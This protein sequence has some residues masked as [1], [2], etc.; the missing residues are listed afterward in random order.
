MPETPFP[1]R[2][3]DDTQ[4][5]REFE[6]AWQAGEEPNPDDFLTR[7]DS[8][9][10]QEMLT[11]LLE[12]EIEIRWRRWYSLQSGTD[13]RMIVNNETAV[14]DAASAANRPVLEFYLEEYPSM[15]ETAALSSLVKKE[16]EVRNAHGD[17]V[18]LSEYRER[19]PELAESLTVDESLVLRDKYETRAANAPSSEPLNLDP[20]Q[21]F[22]GYELIK[23]IGSGGMGLVYLA[24]QISADRIVALKILRLDRIQASQSSGMFLERFRVEARATSRIDHPGIVTIYD[25]GEF[26]GLPYY[27]MKY[28]EGE[29]LDQLHTR[30]PLSQREAARIISASARA[31]QAA[32]RCGILHRDLK[33][34]NILIDRKTGQPCLADFGLAKLI[35]DDQSQT[36][37][38]DVLGT[39]GFMSPEQAK[40]SASVTVATDVYGLGATLYFLLTGKA[41]FSGTTLVETLR[42]LVNDP[43][44]PPSSHQPEL[45]SDLEVICLK[46][47]EKE[48]DKRYASA[49]GFADDLDRWLAGKP[50]HARPV[51]QAERIFRWC[52]RNP[53]STTLMAISL[54]SLFVALAASV[55]G[56]VRVSGALAE[57]EESYRQARETVNEFFTTVSEDVLLQ[58]PAMQPLRKEL[59][60]KA[61]IYYRDFQQTRGS[62]PG[63]QAEIAENHYRIGRIEELIEDRETALESYQRA[64]QLQ[65]ALIESAEDPGAIQ[66]ALSKTLNRQAGCHASL[67]DL[68]AASVAVEESL[69]IRKQLVQDTPEDEERVRLL[70]NA[71][72]NLGLLDSREGSFDEAVKRFQ[73]S[74]NRRK[75][76]L[77]SGQPSD[78]NRDQGMCYYNL[79]NLEADIERYDLAAGSIQRAI[80]QFEI[81]LAGSSDDFELRRKL[82][83]S[84][85]LQ[86]ELY[87]GNYQS[88]EA[89]ESYRLASDFLE[90]LLFENPQ[91]HPLREEL[92]QVEL[93][94]GEVY[95]EQQETETSLKSLSNSIDQ[96]ER[97]P[98]LTLTTQ[99]MLAKALQVRAFVW[100]EMAETDRARDDLERAISLLKTLVVFAPE[101]NFLQKQLETAQEQLRSLPPQTS[102]PEEL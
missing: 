2:S 7:V 53:F 52:K 22:D 81:C 92:A 40:S 17:D 21:E 46:S 74:L 61:L 64:E 96:M 63:L 50:I 19:F 93:M 30:L 69:S 43:V 67:G 62:H 51:S 31:L 54:C 57:S 41:P 39:P 42:L 26:D 83:L 18:A 79:A 34:Q 98:E 12:I 100:R 55:I 68:Q 58:Q 28:V 77:K 38:G 94:R 95:F 99:A 33:P 73:T 11:E 45:D 90:E 89:I 72:M 59:L 20:T 56:Y 5:L 47:L 25:V 66:L 78:M 24:R 37:E 6:E 8:K 14:V 1:N 87:F 71:E 10:R 88:S 44:V 32:H 27:S 102:K 49:G 23:K 85:R 48:P 70:A 65:R 86:G 82:G 91:V 9:V 29:D 4:I 75:P 3:E 76:F 84:Y 80:D 36:R 60:S 97:L 16:I 35:E 13:H 101:D 15:K